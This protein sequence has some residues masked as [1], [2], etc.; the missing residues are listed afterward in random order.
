[1][2]G[3]C[4]ILYATGLYV[5]F[6]FVSLYLFKFIIVN[7]IRFFWPVLLCIGIT[8]ISCARYQKI[9]VFN[10]AQIPPAPD[11]T[12]M[13]NWAAH[14]EKPDSSD[15]KPGQPLRT[16]DPN[17]MVDVF[18]IHPTTFTKQKKIGNCNADVSDA[19][20]NLKTDRTA[21]LFQASAFQNGTR[22]FAPRYRQAHFNNYF[23]K[24][25]KTAKKA[26]E[27][28]YADVL[29]AFEYYLREY[30]EGR[31]FIIASHSQ[32]TTHAI[33]LIKNLIDGRALQEKLV[34]AYLVGMD[35]RKDTF[36]FIKP[37]ESPEETGCII[38]WRTFKKG[39]H[40]EKEDSL[41]ILVTNPITWTTNQ[42]YAP[43][44]SNRPS[45]LRHFDNVYL[46]LTDAQVYSTV[47][48]VTKPKFKGS[49]LLRTNNYHSADINFFY[50]SI[51][52]NVGTRINQY[53]SERK[54]SDHP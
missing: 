22:V 25:K 41:P 18:F 20:L 31:P 44:E 14:P 48:W 3:K 51:E 13:E 5:I 11:Y 9:P 23:T 6:S 45:L 2:S 8:S 33:P 26:F 35:V 39:T 43:K 21:I 17:A 4:I 52:E 15:R 27:V 16:G 50:F 32:G 54:N 12:R 47:L 49:F 10:E 24:D 37:C 30:N 7:S 53:F 42:Q 38:S 34:A 19:A 29:N 28:A 36:R 1:M 46:H 40:L